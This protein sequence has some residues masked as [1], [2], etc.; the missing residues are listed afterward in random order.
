MAEGDELGLL[1]LVFL[2][3]TAPLR[4]LRFILEQIRDA[5]DR[6]LYDP[7]A[8]ERKLI[9]ARVLYELGEMPAAEYQEIEAMVTERL[10]E[11]RQEGR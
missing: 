8:V 11:I 1:D 3:V 7:A 9:E 4:G 2:P 6:E 10:R 5:A